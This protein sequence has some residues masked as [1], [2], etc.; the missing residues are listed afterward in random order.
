MDLAYL[1]EIGLACSSDMLGRALVPHLFSFF[2]FFN[3]WPFTFV[4][5]NCWRFHGQGLQGCC[6]GCRLG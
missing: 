6:W 2:L 5:P 1:V 4:Y 3:N